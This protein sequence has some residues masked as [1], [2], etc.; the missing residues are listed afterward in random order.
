MLRGRAAA[1][2]A[3]AVQAL[4]PARA[5]HMAAWRRQ[6][7]SS[8]TARHGSTQHAVAV[9]CAAAACI[10][11][12]TTSSPEHHGVV[13][14]HGQVNV[15]KVPGAVAAGQPARGAP[16]CSTGRSVLCAHRSSGHASTSAHRTVRSCHVCS[17]PPTHSHDQLPHTPTLA[18]T[19]DCALLTC[20][21]GRWVPWRGRRGQWAR[22]L[23]GCRT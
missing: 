3:A 19:Q 1:R 17:L 4:A 5:R 23:T 15:P 14:H 13:D 11:R 2:T 6:H 9:Q 8:P 21:A 12:S 18:D 16:V 7:S 22:C 10:L 20:C